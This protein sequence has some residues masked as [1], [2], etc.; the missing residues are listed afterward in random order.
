MEKD[1]RCSDFGLAERFV[2]RH[3]DHLRYVIDSKLW[4]K[5]D[6]NNWLKVDVYDLHSLARCTIERLNDELNELTDE[7]SIK[8]LSRFIA[9]CQ[10]NPMRNVKVMIKLAKFF[11]EIQIKSKDHIDNMD[12]LGVGNGAIDMRTCQF[13]PPDSKRYL[14]FLTEVNYVPDSK[15]PLFEKIVFDAFKGNP[16]FIRFFQKCMGYALTG[17]PCHK[18]MLIPYGVS[19]FFDSIMFRTI[20]RVLGTHAWNVKSDTIVK[21]Y[22]SKT[23]KQ[24]LNLRSARF[25]YVSAHDTRITLDPCLVRALGWD[26]PIY[27]RATYA[28]LD[29]NSITPTWLAV[30]PLEHAPILKEYN[31]ATRERLRFLPIFYNIDMALSLPQLS[32]LQEDLKTEY[33]GILFWLIKGARLYLEEGLELPEVLRKPHDDFIKNGN[34]NTFGNVTQDQEAA[35]LNDWLENKFDIGKNFVVT[36]DQIL[37]S[38]GEYSRETG[39]P[40]RTLNWLTKR[41]ENKGFK[42]IENIKLPNGKRARGFIGLKLKEDIAEEQEDDL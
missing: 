14:T 36:H 22:K 9:K 25:V 41:L 33:E 10:N 28:N 16:E 4:L 5:W 18:F 12:L 31:H 15:C 39:E 19:D 29:T 8:E 2:A 7:H 27:I 20:V 38:W 35:S 30:M 11:T 37:Y 34:V 13:L 21:D 3:G 32:Q 24:L 26:S 6:G 42:R 40:P 1:L 17:R 23:R